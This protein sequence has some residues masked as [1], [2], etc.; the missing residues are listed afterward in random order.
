[1]DFDSVLLVC[2]GFSRSHRKGKAVCLKEDNNFVIG[3]LLG[4]GIDL[5]ALCVIRDGC[6]EG[7]NYECILG[8]SS[9]G[10]ILPILPVG[11][12]ISKDHNALSKK[13]PW[14]PRKTPVPDYVNL[15]AKHSDPI[16]ELSAFQ[17][18]DREQKERSTRIGCIEVTVSHQSIWENA[19]SHDLL[20]M[21]PL[22]DRNIGYHYFF[23]GLASTGIDRSKF[24]LHPTRP[25]LSIA[26]LLALSEE[27]EWKRICI[28]P[29]ANGKY[30][31][32]LEEIAS[33]R[34]S[35]LQ[36]VKFCHL[37]ESDL[38]YLKRYLTQNTPKQA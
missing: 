2:N 23:D 8:P 20:L 1:M 31:Q 7:G 38:K 17:I 29:I 34:G 5:A 10:R 36:E 9:I 18:C 33:H 3:H 13:L 27:R 6:A 14:Y 15:F 37:V 32:I 24:M 30:G 19:R 35:S 25:V 11:A 12:T 28:G 26:E 21:A 16:S 4:R 22:T